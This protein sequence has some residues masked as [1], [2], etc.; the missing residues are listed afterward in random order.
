[1][2]HTSGGELEMLRSAVEVVEVARGVPKSCRERW[3]VDTEGRSVASTSLRPAPE[4]TESPSQAC[5]NGTSYHYY[6]TTFWETS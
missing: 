6:T 3:C 1:M 4:G 2:C 5:H